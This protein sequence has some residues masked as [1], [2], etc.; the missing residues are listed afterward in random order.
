MVHGWMLGEVATEL[1]ASR[2]LSR[3]AANALGSPEGPLMAAH[4]KRFVHDA[5]LRAANMC[6]QARGGTG[7]VS[8]YGLDLPDL[9]MPRG[10]QER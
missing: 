6:T 10:Y 5:A 7:L 3:A 2:L 9:P 4:A 1:E 8:L